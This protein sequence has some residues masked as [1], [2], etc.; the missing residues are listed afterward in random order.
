MKEAKAIIL[1][2]EGFKI[3]YKLRYPRVNIYDSDKTII[4][5]SLENSKL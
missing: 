2:I 1:K 5:S 4:E 3:S